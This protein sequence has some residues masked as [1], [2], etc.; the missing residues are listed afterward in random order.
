V[1]RFIPGLRKTGI[2]GLASEEAVFYRKINGKLAL[3]SSIK[4]SENEIESVETIQ[5]YRNQ[6]YKSSY[7]RDFFKFE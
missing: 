4:T 5:F 1:I 6:V 7:K 2:S 3:Y